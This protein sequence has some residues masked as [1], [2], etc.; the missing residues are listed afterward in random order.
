MD[1]FN[2]PLAISEDTLVYVLCP[3]PALLDKASVTSFAA[4]ISAYVD[5]LLPDFLWHRDAFELKVAS[6]FDSEEYFL[7]G[8]M[9]V[10]D[11]VDDE[12]CAVWLLKQISSK[13]DLAIRYVH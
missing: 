6:R 7:E 12:W 4:C 9:R 2:R 11:C 8:R 3:P 1:I 13:W 5:Q 10:G